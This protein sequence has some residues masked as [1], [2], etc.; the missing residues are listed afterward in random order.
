MK[1]SDPCEM[2]NKLGESYNFSHLN[3]LKE[4]LGCSTRKGKIRR[5]LENSLGWENEAERPRWL[6]FIGQCK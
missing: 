2:G 6:E 5:N 3:A 1:D 4:F